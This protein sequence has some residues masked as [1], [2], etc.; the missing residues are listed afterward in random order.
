MAT[1][2]RICSKEFWWY[3]YCH[4][5]LGLHLLVISIVSVS[6]NIRLLVS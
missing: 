4:G 2:R 6:I 3:M 5:K 1:I